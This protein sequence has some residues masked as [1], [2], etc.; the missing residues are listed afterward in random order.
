S[1]TEP[2]VG[3][4]TITPIVDPTLNVA[5]NLATAVPATP[6]QTQV[7]ASA[8]GAY[9]Q[10]YYFETCPVQCIAL[11]LSVNGQYVN[12]TNF[13]VTKGTSETIAATAVD[14]QG[15]IVPK[16]SLTWISSQPAALVPGSATSGCGS[17]TTCTVSTQQ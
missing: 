7:I 12:Q 4:S 14:V 3:V 10:P 1:W 2:T 13:V 6:G 9:S 16:P 11:Q 8:S 5:T 15:C 17:G